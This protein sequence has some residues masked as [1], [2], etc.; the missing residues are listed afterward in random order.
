MPDIKTLPTSDLGRL[1][2]DRTAPA[3][4]GSASHSDGTA[5][6]KTASTRSSAFKQLLERRSSE[7]PKRA[8]VDAN[9]SQTAQDG[10]TL[11]ASDNAADSL[12]EATGDTSAQGRPDDAARS[13]RKEPPS[14]ANP[15]DWAGSLMMTQ[16]AA[17]SAAGA[18]ATNVASSAPSAQSALVAST[19][20][21][22]PTGATPAGAGST[23]ALKPASTA[24]DDSAP[25][26]P[27]KDA[28]TG[29]FLAL[30]RQQ[31]LERGRSFLTDAMSG[32]LGARADRGD[33]ADS[34]QSALGLAA[35][36]DPTHAAASS[37]PAQGAS[38]TS[39]DNMSFS[40]LLAPQAQDP[41]VGVDAAATGGLSSL[42][43]SGAA[44][45]SALAGG[46]HASGA[47]SGT[48]VSAAMAQ[49]GIDA[50]VGSPAFS[51]GL[52]ERLSWMVRDG[53][54]QAQLRLNPEHLGPITVEI[55][56]QGAAAQVNFFA[57]HDST[58]QAIE[59][60]LPQLVSAFQSEGLSLGGANVQ[61]QSQQ[62]GQG[63]P[64][65]NPAKSAAGLISMGSQDDAPSLARPGAAR[66]AN[67]VLDL[68]A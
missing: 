64:G 49:Y 53:Q 32:A 3:S 59:S 44:G 51:A 2:P 29:S 62:G 63:E 39:M 35:G 42:M 23:G 41:V 5:S 15:I 7:T 26:A 47:L 31:V 1:Q 22:G 37:A 40:H 6:S 10:P 19:T 61:A 36:G 12:N 43:I 57:A 18:V 28:S 50:P 14:D 20:T 45:A 67:G 30:H 27:S 68:Y 54:T 33:A 8:P 38:A 60:S 11:A 65:R 46:G 34:T 24:A 58:R 25:S 16:S 55:A 66:R 21:P 56:M 4:G 13:S 48:H 52:G 9:N 17:V